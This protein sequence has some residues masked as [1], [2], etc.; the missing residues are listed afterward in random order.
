MTVR[1]RHPELPDEQTIDV[2]ESAVPLHRAAGWV[3]VED[4]PAT[5]AETSEAESNSE[6]E[7]PQPPAVRKRRRTIEGE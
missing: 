6:A 3:V 4:A 2:A 7:A 5:P 1:L